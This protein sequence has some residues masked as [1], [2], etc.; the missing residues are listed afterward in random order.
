MPVMDVR[1]VRVTV[2][3]PCVG[4]L[5]GVRFALRIARIMLV[6][7]VLVVLV[8]MRVRER[9]VRMEVL[10]ALGEME[11]EPERHERCRREEQWRHPIVP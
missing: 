2:R 7:V 1:R 9:L 4:V 5:V 11:P 10:V 6:L 3:E 8:P